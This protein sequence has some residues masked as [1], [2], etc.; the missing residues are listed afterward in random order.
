MQSANASFESTVEDYRDLLVVLQA[1]AADAYMGIRTAQQRLLFTR[2]NVALQ[3]KTLKL[4]K[5]RYEAELT[6]EL[7]VRQAEMNIASTLALIPQLEVDLTKRVNQL[8]FLAGKQPG[9]YNY[10]LNVTNAVTDINQLPSMLPAN[11]LRNRPDIRAAERRLAAQTAMIGVAS[12]DLYPMFS[13]NGFFDWQASDTGDW[14]NSDARSYGFGPSFHW[15]IFNYGRVKSQIFAEEARTRQAQADYEQIVLAAWQESED[16]LTLYT[17]EIDRK[18]ILEQ[19]VK[20]AQRSVELVNTLYKNGLTDFQNV[21]DM[22][23][24]LF[25]QQDALALSKGNMASDLIAIYKAFGGGWQ[26]Q[27]EEQ[28]SKK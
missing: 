5:D 19:A 7:D 15:S 12:G 14:F 21:L 6:G 24:E 26:P 28:N 17:K 11:L 2:T 18:K 25:Q 8:C 16:A 9:A 1:S 4:T 3:K 20:A 27:E 22:Q 23:R 13:L 10:L